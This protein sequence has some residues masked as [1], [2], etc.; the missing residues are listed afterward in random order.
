MTADGPAAWP[1]SSANETVGTGADASG[2]IQAAKTHSANN[3]DF[4][5]FAAALSVLVSHCYP[6][7]GQP[8]DLLQ[9]WT[10]WLTLGGVAVDVF[11]VMSGFLIAQSWTRDPNALRFLR[12]RALRILPALYVL[13]LVSYLLAGPLLTELPLSV[14]FSRAEFVSMLTQFGVFWLHGYEP[15]VF[16]HSILPGD[17]NGSLWTIP[18]EVLCY[19]VALALGAAG[20]FSNRWT[21]TATAVITFGLYFYCS[22]FMPGDPVLLYMP[23]KLMTGNAAFFF[24]GSALFFWWPKLPKLHGAYALIMLAS[25]LG[26]GGFRAPVVLHL[27]L[28]FLVMSMA[29]HPTRRL[30]K[31]GERGDYSYGIYLY[32]FPVSQCVMYLIG[33]AI[34]L[35]GLIIV[36]TAVTMVCAVL[37]WRFVERPS[38]KL[39]RAA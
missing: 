10:G 29:L 7:F 15:G 37:S 39:K 5:R 9:Q 31:F 36:S 13:I 32:A 28:P 24:A 18:L 2:T 34:T 33:P 12:N 16:V 23:V 25:L 38:L 35:P 30:S 11:F 6:I 14:Y 21:V 1:A 27:L 8:F 19:L 17:F 3:L 22:Y 20:L 26:M 4:M